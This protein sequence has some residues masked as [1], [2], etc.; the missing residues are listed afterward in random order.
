MRNHSHTLMKRKMS[1]NDDKI[2]FG[3]GVW[4]SDL[5]PWSGLSIRVNRD[6]KT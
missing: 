1:W 3:R 4:V 5:G 2:L 6:L